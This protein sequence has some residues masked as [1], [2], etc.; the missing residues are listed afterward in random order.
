MAIPTEAI[1]SIPR[2]QALIDT[3][4]SFHAGRVSR[5]ALDAA[6]A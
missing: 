5:E 1:G 2:P 4:V 3:M 6:Y